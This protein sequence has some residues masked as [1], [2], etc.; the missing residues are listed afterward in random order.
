MFCEELEGRKAA[1]TEVDRHP[2]VAVRL[3]AVMLKAVDERKGAGLIHSS[4]DPRMDND[5][6]TRRL[7]REHH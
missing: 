7:Q 4:V 1:A 5:G 6:D 2:A 3:K